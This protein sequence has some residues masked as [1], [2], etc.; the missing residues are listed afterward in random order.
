MAEFPQ[1]RRHEPKQDVGENRVPT[2]VV[3]RRE[4]KIIKLNNGLRP[5][6]ARGCLDQGSPICLYSDKCLEGAHAL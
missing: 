1:K 6:H 4:N 2:L 5:P 3:I